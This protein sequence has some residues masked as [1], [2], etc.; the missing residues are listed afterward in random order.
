MKLCYSIQIWTKFYLLK[1]FSRLFTF[2]GIDITGPDIGRFAFILVCDVLSFGSITG[3]IWGGHICTFCSR[4]YSQF[5]DGDGF[6]SSKFAAP[7]I[8]NKVTYD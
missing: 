1:E 2:S 7:K 5:E 3:C 8:F 6:K 4:I